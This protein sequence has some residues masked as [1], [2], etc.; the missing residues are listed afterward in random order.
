VTRL[1]WTRSIY[2]QSNGQC[3]SLFDRIDCN[4]LVTQSA[5]S[6]PA[7]KA[8]VLVRQVFYRSTLG[9]YIF[10]RLIYCSYT[11]AIETAPKGDRL[12]IQDFYRKRAFANLTARNFEIAK[13]DAL[14]SCSGDILDARAFYCAGRAAYELGKYQ[15]SKIYFEK[16]LQYSPNESKFKKDNSRTFARISEQ[17]N[18]DYDFQAMIAA[19]IN[20]QVHLGYA[21]F[22][23]N[24]AVGPSPHHGRG[25]FATQ[26]IEAG[27]LVLCEKAFC[28]PD[29]YSGS[30]ES[31]MV[32]YNF[33]TTS[34]TERAA[35]PALFLQL[36]QKVS[37]SPHLTK[38]FFD[39]DSGNYLRSGK[40]GALLDGVPIIDS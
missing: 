15:E 37:N 28:L 10:Y 39:L 3:Q 36:V 9:V 38:R 13:E 19:V 23:R 7:S 34:R 12:L 32:L 40:E 11:Q 4:F 30:Q 20:R 14:A 22:L 1:T 35:Q 6:Y 29:K 21:D 5:R 25:L 24:T 2:Q 17:E 16:T 18:G 33:N 8:L 31:E 26:F 27:G